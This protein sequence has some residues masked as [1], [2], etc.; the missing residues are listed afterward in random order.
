MMVAGYG[1][2]GSPKSY[3]VAAIDVASTRDVEQR[4]IAV[5]E[6]IKNT[7]V[8]NQIKI[9]VGNHKD[10]RVHRIGSEEAGRALYLSFAGDKLYAAK[11]TAGLTQLKQM[12]QSR[13]HS[14]DQL[15]PLLINGRCLGSSR[16]ICVFVGCVIPSQRK[17]PTGN[18]SMSSAIASQRPTQSVP[19]FSD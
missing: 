4:L 14:H 8:A 9:G 6:A 16:P 11:G 1:R 5:A 12:I 13:R 18:S 7:K 10:F 19:V 15:P 17:L 2:I 3:G